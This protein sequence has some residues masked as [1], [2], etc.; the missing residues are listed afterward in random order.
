MEKTIEMRR[1]ARFDLD[2]HNHMEPYGTDQY[3]IVGYD[4]YSGGGQYPIAGFVTLWTLAK[5]IFEEWGA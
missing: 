3:Q 5:F 4:V 2:K 1:F